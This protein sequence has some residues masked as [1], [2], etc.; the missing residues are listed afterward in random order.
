MVIQLL[1]RIKGAVSA[2]FNIRDSDAGG[3]AQRFDARFILRLL[4][5]D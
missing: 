1:R 2:R 3:V 4:I 5:L